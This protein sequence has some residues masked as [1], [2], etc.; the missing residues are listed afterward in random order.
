[1]IIDV[2]EEDIDIIC[3]MLKY[4]LARMHIKDGYYFFVKQMYERYRELQD[5]V[6]RSVGDRER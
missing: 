4:E 1:M 6:K 5:E 2:S 3:V